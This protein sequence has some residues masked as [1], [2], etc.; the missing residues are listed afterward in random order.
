MTN[1]KMAWE[2][3]KVT[4]MWVQDSEAVVAACRTAARGRFTSGMVCDI[5]SCGSSSAS[6]TSYKPGQFRIHGSILPLMLLVPNTSN[7]H[8]IFKIAS[9]K[10]A[11][12]SPYNCIYLLIAPLSMLRRRSLLSDDSEDVVQKSL[13]AQVT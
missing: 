6:P 8:R 10:D 13:L 2:K 4:G 9:S 11:E 3:E 1:E 7:C 12:N 5:P